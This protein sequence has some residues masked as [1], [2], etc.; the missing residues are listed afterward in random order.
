[1]ASVGTV[2]AQGLR[3]TSSCRATNGVTLAWT[4]AVAGQAYTL[5]ARERLANSLWLTVDATQGWPALETQWDETTCASQAMRF[6]RV[7]AVPPATRGKLLSSNLLQTYTV[8]ALNSLFSYHGI[9]VTA[10]NGVSFYKVVYE[11]IDPLGGRTQASGAACLPQGV[12]RALPLLSYQH[13]TT[14]ETND[15]ASKGLGEA[16]AGLVFASVGYATVLPDYLGLG[17]SPG[18]HPYVHA[19]SEATACVDMLRAGRRFCASNSV[20]LNGQI[21]LVGY[22]QGGHATMALHR[23]LEKYHT[24]EFAITASAPMAGPYDMSGVELNDLLSTRCPP[25]PCY[26]AFV[27][28]AYQRVYALASDWSALLAA[29]YDTTIPPLFN[30]STASEVID[31]CLPAC[32]LSALLSAEALWSLQ[33]D[34]GSPLRQAL[35][36]NDLTQWKPVAPMQLYH[37]G[38]DADVL[39]ANSQVAYS[40]FVARGAA[41]VLLINPVPSADHSGCF[42]PS[43]SGAKVWFDSL[44]Q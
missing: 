15:V 30:G 22:S 24:N 2:P 14:T 12:G 32:N 43:L 9:P 29:P 36:D 5:Q 6:Y 33:Y 42:V 4:N 25:N 17:D 34:P 8:S 20:P 13:G 21:F 26:Y 7:I 23:E 19:R 31:G 37:C 16:I 44:K 40:N 10:Q 3:F 18:F 39:Y 27:L 1:M 11:T 35:R 41:Q 28:T 38:A